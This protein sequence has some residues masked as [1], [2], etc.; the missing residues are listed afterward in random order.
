MLGA[1]GKRTERIERTEGWA[2][3]RQPGRKWRAAAVVAATALA[4]PS[5]AEAQP[6]QPAM[7]NLSDQLSSSLPSAQLPQRSSVQRRTVE[8]GGLERSYM[9]SLPAGAHR[10]ENL[11]LILVFHGHGEDAAFNEVYSR[12]DSADAVVAYLQGVDQSWAPAPYAKTTGEQDLA[13][14]DAVRDQLEGEFAIDRSR[15]IAAGHSNGGGFAEYVGCHRPGDFSGIATVSAA[16]YPGVW[17]NCSPAVLRRIDFHGTGDTTMKYDGGRS[18]GQ[19]YQPVEENLTATAARNGCRDD[20]VET[21]V[22]DAIVEQRWQGCQA[23]V[24]HYRISGGPHVW[25]GSLIDVSGTVPTDFATARILDFF[26][27]GHRERPDVPE[28]DRS[29]LGTLPRVD[30]RISA[31]GQR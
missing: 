15:V 29:V 17:E 26:S 7:P 4:V 28:I 30:E 16:F 2:E 12:M 22:A 23:D 18:H 21:N 6:I 19:D 13:F 8:A 9:L 11:P 25:P 31:I 10:R 24:V 1:L 27:I 3:S 5:V 14:V 20:A